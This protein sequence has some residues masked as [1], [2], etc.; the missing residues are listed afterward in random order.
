MTPPRATELSTAESRSSL[1][2]FGRQARQTPQP[3]LPPRR[4]TVSVGV[5]LTPLS[6]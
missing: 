4:A 1:A 5:V 6:G 3:L 2:L